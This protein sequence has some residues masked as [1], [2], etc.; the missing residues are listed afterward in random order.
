MIGLV[1]ICN[2]LSERHIAANQPF[3][4]FLSQYISLR[5]MDWGDISDYL[6]ITVLN[7][8]LIVEKNPYTQSELMHIFGCE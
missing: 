8:W 6:D 4:L 1:I 3:Q 7:D 5:D 2:A